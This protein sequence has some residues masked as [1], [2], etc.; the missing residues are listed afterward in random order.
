MTGIYTGKGA[1]EERESLSLL[2]HAFSRGSS[3]TE[4]ALASIEA[5]P[6]RP[7]LPKMKAAPQKRA[8]NQVDK[9]FR[10]KWTAPKNPLTVSKKRA[11]R[12][13]ANVP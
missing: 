13:L 9:D 11:K 8:H 1:G 6:P 5:R 2:C 4:I 7:G 10:R 3:E 12:A